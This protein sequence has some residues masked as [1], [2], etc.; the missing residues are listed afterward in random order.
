[1]AAVCGLAAA[2]G[3]GGNGG[4][5][6]G[7][8]SI[9]AAR[10]AICRKPGIRDVSTNGTRAQTIVSS[11]DGTRLQD[12]ATDS[13][14]AVWTQVGG[15][16]GTGVVC[17]EVFATRQVATLARG[18]IMPLGLA[19]TD[20][21]V[22]FVA[23]SGAG[24]SLFSV[25]HLGRHVRNLADGVA[26]P[27]A[28]SGSLV[29]YAEAPD[30]STGR[31]TVIDSANNDKVAARYRFPVCEGASCTPVSSIAV[32]PTGAA[33]MQVPE[34][35]GATGVITIRPSAGGGH[36]RGDVTGQLY[37]SDAWALYG[38][39][40]GYFAWPYDA[41]RPQ[42]IGRFGGDQLLA[43]AQGHYFLLHTYPNGTQRVSAISAAT[44]HVTTLD[45]LSLV[46]GTEHTP[47]LTSF[48]AGPTHFC[49]AVNVFTT[50]TPTET[51]IPVGAY[52][53]CGLTP[54]VG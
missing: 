53:R 28:S 11:P 1:V 41:P 50:A 23:A 7:S 24:G 42:P 47:V 15:P 22:Y 29:A 38:T 10:T 12:I 31:V 35:A 14:Y 25:D 30:N 44:A 32:A 33:W 45:S 49:E 52:V 16:S 39:T 20:Q 34:K 46:G 40:D 8:S 51:E 4:G 27:I 18:Q 3:G 9:D 37:P 21:G 13:R 2:C 36:T 43:Y 54:R 48:T 5:D 6:A 17:Q 26:L 19:S